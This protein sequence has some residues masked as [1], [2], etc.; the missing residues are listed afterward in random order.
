MEFSAVV[1]HIYAVITGK[2]LLEHTWSTIVTTKLP[3]SIHLYQ[4][5]AWRVAQLLKISIIASLLSY[6]STVK[7]T[8]ALGSGFSPCSFQFI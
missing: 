4:S 7:V 3:V 8:P 5:C 1:P 6:H 2:W